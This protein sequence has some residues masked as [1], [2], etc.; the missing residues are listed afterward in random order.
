MNSKEIKNVG[1]MGFIGGFL[2]ISLN[3]PGG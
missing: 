3:N 1:E 2:D